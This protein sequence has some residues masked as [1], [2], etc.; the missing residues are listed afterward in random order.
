VLREWSGC[1]LEDMKKSL[2]LLED[3]V[4]RDERGRREGTLIK[5]HVLLFFLLD[6]RV[7]EWR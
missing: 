7:L 1:I 5:I 2:D 3:T 4:K 6:P